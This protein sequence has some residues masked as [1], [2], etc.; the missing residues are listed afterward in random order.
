[1]G[2]VINLQDEEG[3]T[4]EVVCD[5]HNLLHQILPTLDNNSYQLLKYVDWYGDTVF[6]VLQMK[7]F[8]EEIDRL[9]IQESNSPEKVE[10]LNK[11]KLL[12]KKCQNRVHRYIKFIGD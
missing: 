12:G 10:I 6:N 5:D 4:E 8:L 3:E 9:I 11:I 1:M 7:L 2:L